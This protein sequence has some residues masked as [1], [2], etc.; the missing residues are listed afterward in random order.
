VSFCNP[1]RSSVSFCRRC[2]VAMK[3]SDGSMPTLFFSYSHQDEKLRD[4]LEVHLAALKRQ[5]VI[6][7]WHDRRISAGTELGNAID[8]NLTKRM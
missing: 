6:S 3:E 1:L 7:T 2:T 8:Q 4:Q 5:A